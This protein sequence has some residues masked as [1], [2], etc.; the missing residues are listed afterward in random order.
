MVGQPAESEARLEPS[1]KPLG[2]PLG[3]DGEETGVIAF[4]EGHK[5]ISDA[6]AVDG[7]AFLDVGDAGHS[8]GLAWGI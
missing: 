7:V 1:D 2:N 4:A 8:H 3:A 5:F 6:A